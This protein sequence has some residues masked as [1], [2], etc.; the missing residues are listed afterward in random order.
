MNPTFRPLKRLD[1]ALLSSW[2]GA[3]H[4][5]QRWQENPDP[6]AVEAK[7][8]P[9]V[10][11]TEPTEVFVVD[12][13]GEPVGMIQRYR[14]A[15]YPEWVASLAPTGAPADAAGID[16]LIGDPDRIGQGI[17]SAMISAFVDDSAAWAL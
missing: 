13:D 2:L 11:G 4:V 1:F 15:D 16:Y 9:C 3:P 10:E 7:Y 8:G 14:I 5:F 17:G 12:F 6:A